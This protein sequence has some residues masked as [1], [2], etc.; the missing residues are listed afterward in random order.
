MLLKYKINFYLEK[1]SSNASQ[2]GGQKAYPNAPILMSFAFEGKRLHFYT[3]YRIDSWKWDETTQQVRRNNL[4]R[5]GITAQTIND[6]LFKLSSSVS[7]V[8]QRR[9][10]AGKPISIQAIKEDLILALNEN[11][12]AGDTFF[13]CMDAYI[14]EKEKINTEGTVKKYRTLKSHLEDFQQKAHFKLEFESTGE[15]FLRRFVAF[16]LQE[17]DMVNSTVAKT[18]KL[19]KAFLSWAETRGFSQNLSFKRFR[20]NLKGVDSFGGSKTSKVIFLTWPEFEHLYTMP[21]AKPY[22]EHV[23]DVFCFLCAT[24]QRYSDVANLKWSNVKADTLE[25]TTIKTEET[26]KVDLNDY[27]RAILEKYK[28]ANLKDDRCLPVISNQKMN[29]YLKELGRDAGLTSRETIVYY[30]GPQRIEETFD[31]W[32]LLT[33]HVGKKTFVTNAFFWGIPLEVIKQWT[34]NKDDR[35]FKSYY[36]VIDQQKKREMEKFNILSKNIQ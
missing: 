2:H 15:E 20:H 13:D 23:R 10:I 12:S 31:K 14:R 32:E 11:R 24:G 21:I 4:N 8:Y 9:K 1:R 27:S 17:K 30:Q 6:R 22:L 33:T 25:F 28:G 34:G 29:E 7:E 19:V 26:V 16:L 18:I 36:A 35:M 5:N 3:G